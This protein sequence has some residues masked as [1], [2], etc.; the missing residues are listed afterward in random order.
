VS[1]KGERELPVE[2]FF[3]TPQSES[4]REIALRPDEILTEILVPPAANVRNAT[5][6]VRQRETLD[7]PLVTA[8]VALTMKGT[9]VAS[10]RVVLGHVAPTPWRATEAEKVL[11]GK[12]LSAAVIQKAAEAAVTGATPLSRN[13][14]KVQLVR[15]AVRRALEAARPKA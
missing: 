5:Y 11:A 6:E 3:V 2:K 12:G 10:A 4:E 14:Y 13:A 7:W 8:S 15:A 1:A 9:A